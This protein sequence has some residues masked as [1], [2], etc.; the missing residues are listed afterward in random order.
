M[1]QSE[2]ADKSGI[3]ASE[4]SRLENGLGNPT[5]KQMKRLAKGLDIPC[6]HILTMEEILAGG[7]EAKRAK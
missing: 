1:S 7:A 3:E 5:Y 2:V 6:S 4:I